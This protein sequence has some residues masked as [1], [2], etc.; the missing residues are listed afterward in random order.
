MSVIKSFVVNYYNDDH[1]M[2]HFD[3]PEQKDIDDFLYH[4]GH[5]YAFHLDKIDV[6]DGTISLIAHRKRIRSVHKVVD[7]EKEDEG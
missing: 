6:R 2:V 7:P 3:N 5:I 4:E 1:P